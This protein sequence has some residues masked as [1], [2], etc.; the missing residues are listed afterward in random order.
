MPVKTLWLVRHGESVGNVAATRAE[1][2]GLERIPIDIR[3]SDVPLSPTGEQQAEALG[4]WLMEHRAAIETF[5]VSPYLR[6]RQTLAIALGDDPAP[7]VVD[8]RLRDRELGILD[9][10]TTRGV[11]RLH[12]EEAERRRHLGKFYH[13]PPGG[14]SWADVAL[15]LR[16][17]LGDL[18]VTPQESALIVAHDAVVTLITSLLRRMQEQEILE[19]AS[20]NPVLNASVTRLEFAVDD[21]QMPLFSDVSHLR[22][23]GATV[24]VHPGTPDIGDPEPADAPGGERA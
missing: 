4:E 8:E 12:P 19:F 7:V 13:R 14:E 15:R 1:R 17:L 21:W 24:T 3:D 9:L 20:G 5:W 16:S 2:E 22:E 18:L 10:L 6:A 23:E 11:A